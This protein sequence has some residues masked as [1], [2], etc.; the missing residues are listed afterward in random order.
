M[1]DRDDTGLYLKRYT[2]DVFI[3]ALRKALENPTVAAS[4]VADILGCNQ[5]YAVNRLT[6]LAE[7][8]KIEAV[9]KGRAWGFRPKK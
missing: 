5:R 1:S 4:E 3:D 8:G 7:S 9:M 2:D 6:E